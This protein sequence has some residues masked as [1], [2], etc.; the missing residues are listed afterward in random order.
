LEYRKKERSRSGNSPGGNPIGFKDYQGTV[1]VTVSETAPH[2]VQG[3]W[4]V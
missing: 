2:T 3:V 1:L 4:L